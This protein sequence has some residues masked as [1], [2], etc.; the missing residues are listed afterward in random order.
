MYILFFYYYQF[1]FVLSAFAVRTRLNKYKRYA[2]CAVQ[3]MYMT[4]CQFVVYCIFLR[5]FNNHCFYIQNSPT[6]PA[7]ILYNVPLYHGKP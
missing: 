3:F 4:S 7:I 6:E 5:M 2:K 1:L